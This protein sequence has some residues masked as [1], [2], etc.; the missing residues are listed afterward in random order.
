MNKRL[1]N[2]LLPGSMRC[3]TRLWNLLVLIL[4]DFDSVFDRRM[5]MVEEGR[6]LTYYYY[7]CLLILDGSDNVGSENRVYFVNF[8]NCN[9]VESEC[10]A[11]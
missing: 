7:G 9:G 1:G 4:A 2:V 10:H 5:Q 8:N 3:H 6:G 11:N